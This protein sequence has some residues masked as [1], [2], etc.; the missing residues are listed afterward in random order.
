MSQTND[1]VDHDTTTNDRVDGDTTTNDRVDSRRQ[2]VLAAAAE[3]L[4]E[5]AGVGFSMRE[6]ADRA[7]VSAGAVYQW[8]SGKAEILAVLHNQ[9]FDEELERMTALPDSLDFTSMVREVLTGMATIWSDTGHHRTTII[10]AHDG[11]AH[12]A[13]LDGVRDRFRLLSACIE[14]RLRASAATDGL[15]LRP[16][17]EMIPWLWAV[18]IGAGTQLID[19]RFVGRAGSAAYLAG[20]VAPTAAGLLAPTPTHEASDRG[21]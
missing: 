10:D 4:E 16:T 9:R 13:F 15:Q 8:F 17:E 20:L 7:G 14:E 3:L 11:S 6:V 18:C 2:Q 5:H 12:D 21:L 1:N 19:T